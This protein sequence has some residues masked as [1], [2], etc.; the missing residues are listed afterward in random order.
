MRFVRC[1]FTSSSVGTASTKRESPSVESASIHTLERSERW[2]VL[3]LLTNVGE[4]WLVS[5][6]VTLP[7]NQ[8]NFWFTQTQRV[9]Q[10]A[11]QTFGWLNLHE[12]MNAGDRS[13]SFH[14][15]DLHNLSEHCD[16]VMQVRC[17]LNLCTKHTFCTVIQLMITDLCTEN[18]ILRGPQMLQIGEQTVASPLHTQWIQPA[19]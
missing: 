13:D 11:F 2:R 1:R 15:S 14:Y 12:A 17:S 19:T 8:K 6:S 3:W 16:D 9:F 10:T 5:T 4:C 7:L 18:P